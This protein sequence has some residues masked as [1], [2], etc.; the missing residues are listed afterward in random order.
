MNKQD[1]CK[2]ID[3]ILIQDLS[4]QIGDLK[5]ENRF[6][7]LDEKEHK[8]KEFSSVVALKLASYIEAMIIFKAQSD[9]KKRKILNG[10]NLVFEPSEFNKTTKPLLFVANEAKEI[11][12][13]AL[14][15]FD[16]FLYSKRAVKLEELLAS[17]S[18]LVI[19]KMVKQIDDNSK[20]LIK[21]FQKE[22]EVIFNQSIFFLRSFLHAFLNRKDLNEEDLRVDYDALDSGN[23]LYK[24]DT[25]IVPTFLNAFSLKEYQKVLHEGVE[26]IS[27]TFPTSNITKVAVIY[28]VKDFYVEAKF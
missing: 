5:I 27:N 17:L 10:L 25:L 19:L 4:F 1:L 20:G 26:L 6:D 16:E 13:K 14:V 28:L 23:L 22:K 12:K 18:P 21:K 11:E 8:A 24:G 3:Q 15:V 2:R 7:R 9:E